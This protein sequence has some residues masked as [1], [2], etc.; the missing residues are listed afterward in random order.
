MGSLLLPDFSDQARKI[1]YFLKLR[2]ESYLIYNIT[3]FSSNYFKVPLEDTIS[4]FNTSLALGVISISRNMFNIALAQEIFEFP[5]EFQPIIKIKTLRFPVT[6]DPI[7]HSSSNLS[8]CFVL[9]IIKLYY[10]GEIILDLQD[11]LN[12]IIAI[13]F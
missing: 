13:R 2:K 6:R 9:E 8:T 12:V 5:L 7:T 10:V 1:N 3:P 11:P 4:N